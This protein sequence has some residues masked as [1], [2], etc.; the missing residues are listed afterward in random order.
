MVED[1]AVTNAAGK[2]L[3]KRSADYND[4]GSVSNLRLFVENGF[5]SSV[6]NYEYDRY[7]NIS[8]AT[9]PPT[10]MDNVCK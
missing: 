9:M 1:V 10:K 8:R 7:G 4:K 2:L 5:Y 3:R 6:Y